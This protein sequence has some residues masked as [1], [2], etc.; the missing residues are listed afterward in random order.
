M[1]CR[2]PV[3]IDAAWKGG[4]TMVRSALAWATIVAIAGVA[5]GARD[6]CAQS[7]TDQQSSVTD[8]Q[9]PIGDLQLTIGELQFSMADLQF[10]VS[11]FAPGEILPLEFRIEDL[12]AMEVSEREVRFRLSADV[13]FDFGSAD[14]RSEAADMLAGL[15]ERIQTEFPDGVVRVEGHTDSKG[16]TEYNQGLSEQRAETVANWLVEHGRISRDRVATVGVGESQPVAPN[17]LPDGSDDPVGR[18]QNRRVEI[19]VER[20]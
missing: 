14:L 2:L 1:T 9:F 5:S 3:A 17:E 6:A 16:T 13:L 11:D 19:V 12:D 4:L 7:A 18:Q 10:E 8:L 20:Q 15:A